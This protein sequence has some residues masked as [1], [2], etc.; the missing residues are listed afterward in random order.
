MLTKSLLIAITSN[1]RQFNT[2]FEGHIEKVDD[3][4]RIWSFLTCKPQ[5]VRLRSISGPAK[6]EANQVESSQLETAFV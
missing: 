4:A 6:V 2:R 5:P 1:L 3:F